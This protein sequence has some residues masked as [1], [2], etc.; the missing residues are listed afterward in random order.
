MK[1]LITGTAGRVG[2]AIYIK[3]MKT[4]QV[5]GVDQ[6]PCSTADYVGDIRDSNFMTK[7]LKDVEVIIHTA[8]LH[9]PHV[10]TVSDDEFEEINTHATE[11][12]A[13]LGIKQGIKH[14]VF[15]SSTAV[16]G[17]ASTPDG[18][19][20]WVNESI[21]PQPKTIYHKTKIKAEQALEKNI[22]SFQFTCDDS[23]NITVFS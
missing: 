12:L 23:P 15:T 13:L 14:F 19:A 20:G 7:L 1:I 21:V 18:A 11:Q 22:K 9:A 10:G 5:V 17:F 4:H 3:L 2:R 16:Y 6:I 8:A